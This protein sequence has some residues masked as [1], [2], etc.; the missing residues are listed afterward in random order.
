MK[1]I[2]TLGGHTVA[3]TGKCFLPRPELA[4]RIRRKG[5]RAIGE[6]ARMTSDTDIL[7]RRISHNCKRGMYGRKEEGSSRISTC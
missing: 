5:G 6:L 3:L 7:V 1:R 2:K 4:Q